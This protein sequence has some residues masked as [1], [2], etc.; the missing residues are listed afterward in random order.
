MTILGFGLVLAAACCHAIWNFFVKRINGGP[1]LV[2][3]FSVLSVAL[4]L[5]IALVIF[6]QSAASFDLWQGAFIAGSALLHLGYFLLLQ[7]GYRRGDLSLVYPTARATG[8]V[9]SSSFA[10]VILGE[11]LTAQAAVGGIVIVAGVLCLTG[12]LAR[13]GKNVGPSLLFGLTAGGLIGGYTVWDAHTVAALSV[14][15]LLLDY[16]SS[17]GR[18]LVLAPVAARRKELVKGY[19]R[20]H[21]AGVIAIAAFN[22]LAYILVLYALTFTPVVYVAPTRELSVLIT[23]MLGSIVLG[24]GDLRRRL[25][26]AAVILLGVALLATA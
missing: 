11:A 5:P 19:W 4:Y 12:G 2:W 10:V 3:L 24:E 21:R 1:E 17:V 20:E 25:I 13:A 7:Q 9:L 22:P 26:W 18:S 16:A 23:V 8:P 14:P 6:F 15:P